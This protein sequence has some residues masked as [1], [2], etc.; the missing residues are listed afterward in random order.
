[1]ALYLGVYK[2]KNPM[3]SLHALA[4]SH[5]RACR[6]PKTDEASVPIALSNSYGKVF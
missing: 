3:V 1:M 4:H 5:G 6:L 2:S